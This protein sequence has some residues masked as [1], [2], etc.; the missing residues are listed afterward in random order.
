MYWDFVHDSAAPSRSPIWDPVTGFGGNGAGTEPN[1]N[2][3][4]QVLDGPFKDWRPLYWNTMP[5]R[6]GLARNWLPKGGDEPEMAGA[7][8]SAEIMKGVLQETT[9]DGFRKSLEEPHNH[10]HGGIGGGL[11]RGDGP[12]GD[13]SGNNASPNGE[14]SFEALF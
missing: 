12:P 14:S 7:K 10:V 1:G 2:Y 13:L 8:Y 11:V 6:H 3:A 4:P 5:D 9:F